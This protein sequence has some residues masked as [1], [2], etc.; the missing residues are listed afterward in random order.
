VIVVQSLPRSGHPDVGDEQHTY[1]HLIPQQPSHRAEHTHY[2]NHHS[3][4][5]DD[6]DNI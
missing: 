2:V 3:C 1:R 6:F 5:L 4:R